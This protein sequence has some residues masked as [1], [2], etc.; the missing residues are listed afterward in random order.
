MIA[1]LYLT[2]ITVIWPLIIFSSV[3]FLVF[4]AI[5]CFLIK[6]LFKKSLGFRTLKFWIFFLLIFIG[7][8]IS[9]TIIWPITIIYLILAGYAF[10]KIFNLKIWQIIVLLVVNLVL[11]VALPF[12]FLVLTAILPMPKVKWG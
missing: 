2:L 6:Y 3:G 10:H 9:M 12:L 11:I 7:S 1:V 4:L 5:D 8:Y